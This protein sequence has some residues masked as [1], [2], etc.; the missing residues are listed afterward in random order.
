[1][2]VKDFWNVLGRKPKA[3]TEAWQRYALPE[4]VQ[5][6]VAQRLAEC[7]ELDTQIQALRTRKRI[8]GLEIAEIENRALAERPKNPLGTMKIGN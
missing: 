3:E 1:M 5:A 4:Q 7:R 8:L 6:A 2:N